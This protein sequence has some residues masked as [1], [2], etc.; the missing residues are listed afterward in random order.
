LVFF[1]I[2]GII[3]HVVD[4]LAKHGLNLDLHL[5]I[6]YVITDFFSQSLLNDSAEVSFPKLS[7]PI[8]SSWVLLFRKE[9]KHQRNDILLLHNT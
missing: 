7:K 6:F 9:K 3:L 2:G 4:A 5:N 8:L 1:R